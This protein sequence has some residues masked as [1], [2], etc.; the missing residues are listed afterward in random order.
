MQHPDL[1]DDNLAIWQPPAWV[2]RVWRVIESTLGLFT[3]GC[4]VVGRI[5]RVRLVRR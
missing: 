2:A 3:A 5:T 4:P 1:L